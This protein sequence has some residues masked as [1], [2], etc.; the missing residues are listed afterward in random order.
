VLET[1][2]A[3]LR[4]RL[5]AER[6]QRVHPHKDDKVLTSWNGLALSAMARG[7]QVLKD[8]RYLEG[9][10]ACAG[11]L[12]QELFKDGLLLRTWR[13][14]QA[15]TPGFLE[16]YAAVALGLVDL[17]E[18]TF[19]IHWLQ[20]AEQLV[21]LLRERFED[22][23]SGGFYS[24]EVDQQDLILRQKP[25][26]DHSLPSANAMAVRALLRIAHHR[27][28]EDL[29]ASAEKALT[30]FAP[31][32]EQSPRACLGLLEGLELALQG[33]LEIV[34]CGPRSDP[35][36]QSLL[37]R[38]WSRYLAHRVVTLLSGDTEA[39]PHGEKSSVNGLPTVYVCRNR[40]C[41]NPVTSLEALEEVLP[42]RQ[43]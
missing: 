26:F 40:T 2:L 24:T 19:E 28:R 16:D 30:C 10:S 18:T 8:E 11:F 39:S 9:A 42:V 36:M 22:A 43:F 13:Q 34:L 31:I 23:G 29:V 1:K 37:D 32:L 4:Q 17:F 35:R 21:E 15:H 7:Y 41:L 20:W 3:G 6:E 38:I 14:G 12:R 5:W 25:V 27:Q 33:P